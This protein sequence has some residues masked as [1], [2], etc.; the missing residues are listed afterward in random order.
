MG[1]FSFPR[2]TGARLLP[3][4]LSRTG[5]AASPVWPASAAAPSPLL[6]RS[7]MGRPSP[8]E[9]PLFLSLSSPPSTEAWGPTSGPSSTS[10]HQREYRVA[11][12]ASPMPPALPRRRADKIED[13][14]RNLPSPTRPLSSS[15]FPSAR[16]G[17]TAARPS[18]TVV[19]MDEDDTF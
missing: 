6:S 5:P 7:A 12:A 9:R 10:S 2:P 18:S 3:L 16:H 17:H 11:M 8:T 13:C 15:L 4:Y 1:S 14:L 19:T